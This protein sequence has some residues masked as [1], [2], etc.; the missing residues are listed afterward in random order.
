MMTMRTLANGS[1]AAKTLLGLNSINL[2]NLQQVK[3][4]IDSLMNALN[5]MSP[6]E[7]TKE[8][9]EVPKSSART[10]YKAHSENQRTDLAHPKNFSVP[11][12]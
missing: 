9:N 8:K 12:L 4:S 3:V 11:S 2:E 10:F 6:K 5:F 7:K 1:K